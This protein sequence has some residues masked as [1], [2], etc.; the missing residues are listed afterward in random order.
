M[1]CVRFLGRL[2]REAVIA[3]MHQ[4][5]FLVFPAECYE[6]FPLAIAEAFACGVPVIA[7]RLGAMAEIVADGRTGLHFAAGP[8]S[9]P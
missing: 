9:R 3:A 2:S 4:A 6:N 8:R 1:G 5:S 7:T